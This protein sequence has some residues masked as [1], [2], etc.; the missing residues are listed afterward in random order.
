VDLG[1]EGERLLGH[2]ELL[3]PPAQGLAEGGLEGLGTT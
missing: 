1:R 3:A 2:L